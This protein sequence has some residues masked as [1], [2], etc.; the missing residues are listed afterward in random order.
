MADAKPSGLGYAVPQGG[1]RPEQHIKINE[2]LVRLDD[3]GTVVRTLSATG[4]IVDTH[5]WADDFEDEPMTEAEWR[6]EHMPEPPAEEEK[7]APAIRRPKRKVAA[8]GDS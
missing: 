3:G 5:V 7:P 1:V 8:K 4:N 2:S 6:K